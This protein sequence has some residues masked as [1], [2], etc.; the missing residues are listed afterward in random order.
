MKLSEIVKILGELKQIEFKLPNGE[1]VPE[2]FHVTE[3][4]KITKHFID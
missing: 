3:I 4:G 2:H 1:L